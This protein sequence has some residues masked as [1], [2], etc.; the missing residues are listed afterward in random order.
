MAL[1]ATAP[2]TVPWLYSLWLYSL[3]LYLLWLYLLW[4]YVLWHYVLWLYVLWHY[5]LSRL[6]LELRQPGHRRDTARLLL[7]EGLQE[8]VGGSR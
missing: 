7:D 1:L 3:W 2:R 5:L 6:Q 4:H 8:E